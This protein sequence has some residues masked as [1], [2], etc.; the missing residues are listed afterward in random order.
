MVTEYSIIFP[1]H[2]KELAFRK[3]ILMKPNWPKVILFA[4]LIR[5]AIWIWG[6]LAIDFLK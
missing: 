2:Q 5:T 6:R 4:V 1:Y 3:I